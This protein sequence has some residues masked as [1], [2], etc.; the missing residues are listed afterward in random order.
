MKHKIYRILTKKY[1]VVLT[2]L[3]TPLLGFLDRN[4][5]FFAAL[6]VPLLILWGSNFRW[7]DFGLE[8]KIN[9][10]I[11]SRSFII[12][13]LLVIVFYTIEALLEIYFGKIDISSLDDIRGNGVGYIVTLIIVWIFAGFGEEFLFRGYYMKQLAVFFGGSSK[14]WWFSAI[15]ISIYFGVSHMYQGPAGIIGIALWHFCVSMLFYKD[16]KNLISTILIH[17]FYDTIGL[18]LLFFSKEHMIY[19]W[20]VQ[21]LQ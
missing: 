12:A 15:I 14:A 1:V 13:C 8:K 5:V 20:I 19:D 21:L 2:L 10:K 6:A 17:G 4:F 7:A 3:L 11:V 9:T 16:P 18:T